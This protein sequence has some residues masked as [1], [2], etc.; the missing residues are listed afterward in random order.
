MMLT[1]LLYLQVPNRR[2]DNVLNGIAWN[3]DSRRLIVSGKRWPSMFEIDLIPAQNA[4]L[5][6]VRQKCIPSRNIFHL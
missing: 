2:T 4:D 5:S 1:F 3:T 6:L